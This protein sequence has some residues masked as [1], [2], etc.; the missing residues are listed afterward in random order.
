MTI[1]YL[2]HLPAKFLRKVASF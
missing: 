1:S 2:S